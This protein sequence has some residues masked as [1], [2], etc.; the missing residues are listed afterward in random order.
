MSISDSTGERATTSEDEDEPV[1]TLDQEEEGGILAAVF[2]K[3][4]NI[5]KVDFGNTFAFGFDASGLPPM[6]TYTLQNTITTIGAEP[7]GNADV[8][9][10]FAQMGGRSGPI[11]ESG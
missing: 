3:K 7:S 5:A 4:V 2:D 6:S 9:H 10:T 11:G 1:I 8:F